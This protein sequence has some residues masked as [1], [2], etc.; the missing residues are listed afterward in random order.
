MQSLNL[1]AKLMVLHRQILF[2]LAIAAIAEAI[3]MMS[4]EQMPSLHRVAPRYFK[5]VTTSNIW[6]FMLKFCS[7]VVC[8][9]GHDL[10]L[11]GADF[12]S[13]CRCSV[14]EFVGVL[15]FTIAAAYKIDVIGKS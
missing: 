1:L 10:A 11:F 14:Y 15:K 4:A 8:A 9:F 7:D 2:S 3:L 5:L 6:P 12:H 13:I